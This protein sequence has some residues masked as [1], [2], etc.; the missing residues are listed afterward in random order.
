MTRFILR[1]LLQTLPLLL[2]VTLISFI[3]MQL[4][5]GNYLDTLRGQPTI[6]PETIEKLT[7]DFGLDKPWY[8]QYGLWLGNAIRGNFGYSFTY[9]I[10]VFSLIGQRLYYTFI[11]AL[12]S[13]IV[14]WIIAIPLGVY[15]GRH[16]NSWVDRIVSLVSYA[17]SALPGFFVALLMLIYAKNTGKLPLGGATS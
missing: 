8:I 2:A 17:Q 4:A 7:H 15:V 14:A 12:W 11:L 16:R 10:G 3:V 5:P 1:R 13:T 9:K 6:R